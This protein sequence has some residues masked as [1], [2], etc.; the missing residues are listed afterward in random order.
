MSTESSLDSGIQE[1]GK[2]A[3]LRADA[4]DYHRL[5]TRG[6]IEVVA[7]KPLSNQRDLSLAYSPGVAYAC[8]EIAADPSLAA[9][10]TSRGNLV[11]VISNGTAVLGL[12]NIGPLASKPVM[13]GKGCL[14]KKFAGVDVFDLELAELDPDKLVDAI[15]MLEP[16]VGGINLEDIKAPECFYIEKQLRERMNIPV[17]HDDQHGTAIISCAAL[18]N[19]LKVVGKDIGSVKLAA[20]GAGAAAIACLDM[21]VSLGVRRE[22]I[23]VTDSK[24]VIWRGR[25]ANMEANKARYAQDTPA[26]TLADIV[27]G[28]DVFLGCSTA[29]VLTGAMVATMAQRPVI[30]ALANPEP[31]IRPEAAKAARPDCIVA[32]GRSDYPNQVNNVLCFPYIFRGALDCGATRITEEMKLACVGA[33]ASLAEAEPNDAVAAAYAGQDLRF[34]P[35]YIIPKPFDPRLMAA[36]APAVAEAAVASGVATR[37]IHDMD[38][39]RERLAAMVYHTSFFMRPV[40]AKARGRPRRVAYA[41][42]FDARVLRAVQTVVDEGLAKPV[43]IGRGEEIEEAIRAAGLRLRRDVD[44][45]LAECENE[46]TARGTAM[47]AAGE[48][49]ALICGMQGSYDSH[50]DHVKR[51]IGLAPGATTMAAMNALVL[52]R[53]TLFITDTYVNDQPSSAELAAIARM[54]AHELRQFGLEPKVALLS[55]SIFGSSKRPS[56]LRV[57]EAREILA[58]E[59][60]EL[61]VIGEVHG[62]AALDENIRAIYLPAGQ[63][64]FEGSAN[65]LVMPSLDA[66][67][68]LFNVLKVSSGKGVTVGPILL[69]AAKSVHI[70]SPSATVRRIV[71]M[72]ALAVADVKDA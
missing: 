31:E 50:L 68:I 13:E 30:L 49:E 33:I 12:G 63:A 39:Y 54:A 4:L 11:A 69:G 38:A 28:A 3:Q 14:F 52:D 62:D 44:Y 25:E 45:S 66:A 51:D 58:R 24:G 41:E 43:L 65:L 15:A 21:M 56:A 22:N 16:T 18:I 71:N 35:D 27:R 17:F 9:D 2:D 70:L 26:R 47:L 60:P 7:T 42:A 29:G 23:F 46:T 67:N 32:T 19:A 1:P 48:V 8:E 55:H 53:Q 64:N 40:F 61:S 10:Y 57:R 37:P 59:A 6:K 5:P 36:I 34:G 20:S 72:T